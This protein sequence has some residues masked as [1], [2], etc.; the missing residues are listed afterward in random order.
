MDNRTLRNPWRLPTDISREPQV[1][2]WRELRTEDQYLF[3]I[4]PRHSVSQL[5]LLPE[6]VKDRVFR[7]SPIQ[8]SGT[9]RGSDCENG[10][11]FP[12][13]DREINAVVI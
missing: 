13:I 2:I 1:H 6:V 10:D 4:V 9:P 5:Y 11:S 7:E 3:P 12:L 8:E